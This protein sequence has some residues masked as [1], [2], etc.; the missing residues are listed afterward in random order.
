MNRTKTAS[1][2]SKI[3]NQKFIIWLVALA[4]LVS[5][6]YFALLPLR[7]D[8]AENFSAQGDSLLLE[9]KYLEA[10]V[11]YHK[12]EYLCKGCQAEN[13]IQLANNAQLN[14]LELESFL[15]E[16]NS[17]KDLEQ[18][19]AANKVP[20][21]V[22][23]GLETVKK[24][25]EDNEPQLAEIQTELILEMEKD[26]KE[27]WAYLGLARLQTARIVQMS[28]SNRKTKLLSAKEAF[29]KAKELDESYELAK[30][31]LKEVEQLLS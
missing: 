11:E 26:S 14:F 25:I 8:M 22:S 6:L 23:E 15:R 24:M 5:V 31:Y 7:R 20:S 1:P 21:S 29:A 9:K 17:I 16:K 27:T 3:K 28:E 4:A 19:A 12:A 2:G 10:I 30:Q 18:L 13:K